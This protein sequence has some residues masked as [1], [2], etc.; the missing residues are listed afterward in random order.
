MSEAVIGLDVGTTVAKAVLFDPS[1]SNSSGQV[2]ASAEMG[3][4][5]QAYPLHTPRPGW[6]ELDPEDVW[7]ATLRVL[8]AVAAEAPARTRIR[9]IALA[10]Q[11]GTLIPCRA[12]GTPTYRAI[13]WMDQRAQDLVDRW[14]AEGI[15]G[16]VRQISGWSPQP[17]LPL[18]SI[19]WLR[20]AR[21]EVFAA[22]QWFLSVNDFL[23]QRLAGHPA[24]NPSMAGE[25]LLADITTGQWSQ[26]ICELVGIN[27]GQLSPILPSEAPLGTLLPEVADLWG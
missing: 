14:R 8:R 3:V 20:Q 9:A 10:T 22:T 26:E 15:A 1:G 18:P 11:G 27:P 23:A 13:T 6:A 12:D 2:P 21:R 25:M 7:Q 4:A 5:A 19:A 17:G 16:R 24:T